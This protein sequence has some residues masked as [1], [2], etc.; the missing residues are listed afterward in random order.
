MLIQHQLIKWHHYRGVNKRYTFTV[1]NMLLR[2]RFPR[3]IRTAKVLYGDAGELIIEDLLQHGM[4][5]M[6]Q[7][8]YLIP[9]PH[10]TWE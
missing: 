4:S 5:L 10:G 6:S 9:R 8:R 1:D 2:V 3:Y 7:V